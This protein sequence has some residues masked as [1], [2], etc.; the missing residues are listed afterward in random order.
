MTSAKP[1]EES[2]AA[3]AEPQ[4]YLWKFQGLAVQ[5]R[6]RLEVIRH[7]R[8]YLFD[9]VP[10]PSEAGGLLLGKSQGVKTEITGFA[11]IL[12]DKESG[13]LPFVLSDRE[14]TDLRRHIGELNGDD[15]ET[16]VLGYFRSDL[17]NGVCLY[18]QDQDLIRE[19]FS[20]PRSV[21]LV[22]HPRQSGTPTA[23][24]FFWEGGVVF[25]S[26]SFMEFDFDDTVL[27]SESY[28]IPELPAAP[29]EESPLSDSPVAAPSSDEAPA[30]ASIAA[31]RS[32]RTSRL[33]VAGALGGA[34]LI[35]GALYRFNAVPG[36]SK[37]TP[38]APS[39]QTA[40]RSTFGATS[41]GLA[42]AASGKDINISWD[43]KSPLVTDARVALLTIDDG[44]VRRDI[45]LTK[46]Q[47]LSS[48]LMYTRTTD[49]VQIALETFGQDGKVTRENVIAMSQ[50]SAGRNTTRFET[51]VDTAAAS[52]RARQ[53]DQNDEKDEKKAARTFVPPAQA[54]QPAAQAPASVPMPDLPRQSLTALNLQ[55]AAPS[56]TSAIPAPPTRADAPIAAPIAAP[57][58]PASRPIQVVTQTRRSATPLRQV[59]PVLPDNVKALLT[60][61]ANVKVLVRIDATGRVTEAEPVESGGSLNRLLGAAASSA[62]RLWVFNPA[63]E[64]DRKVASELT[65]EFSFV[66]EGKR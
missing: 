1:S 46:D 40:P 38:A 65:V 9:G 39:T 55:Q 41:L 45:S 21:F 2:T 66:P 42:V 62:A 54:I 26:F 50:D 22:V 28:A 64:G 52:T 17:R 58:P 16:I 3:P 25:G 60:G 63:T 11:P 29:I 48:R 36:S 43:A 18:D 10:Q 56:T 6:I 13:G 8:E 59:R 32:P 20:D 31:K 5:I 4:S 12:R 23:G 7:I 61:R 49:T 15:G 34:L 51:R 35:G 47:L 19:Q 14:K 53:E 24:F 33:A 30:F 27:A 44:P 37:G 57:P